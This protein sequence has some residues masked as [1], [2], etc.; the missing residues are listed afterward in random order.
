M[1]LEVEDGTGKSNADAFDALANV[2]TYWDAKGTDYSSYDDDAIE[3]AIRRSTS[4][5]SNSYTWKGTRVNGRDQ[6]LAWPRYGVE[7]S[8]GW[9]V[10]ATEVPKEVKEATAEIALRELV[11]PGSMTPDVTLSDKVKREKVG[12]LEVE[13]ANAQTGAE[14]S[15]PVLLIVRDLIGGLLDGGS[16]SSIVGRAERA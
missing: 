15:R 11:S 8:E 9:Y 10:P 16:G 4:I 14:A 1:A 6:A 7:D 2:K 5:L 12:S 3:Q 13:Y